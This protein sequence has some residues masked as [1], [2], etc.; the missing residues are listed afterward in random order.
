MVDSV[1]NYGI[2]GVSSTVELGKQGA[3]IDASNSSVITIK[4]KDDDLINAAIAEGTDVSHAVTK[5]QLDAAGL[6]KVSVTSATVSYNNTTVL[7]GI[8]SA[9]ATVLSTTVEPLTTWTDADANTNITVGDNTDPDRLFT[10]FDPSVQT[11]DETNHMYTSSE[12]IFI[13]VSQG[14]ASAGTA[15]VSVVHSGLINTSAEAVTVDYLIVGGGGGGG[16][17]YD[18]A[19]GGGGGGGMVL[20]ANTNL[21]VGITYNI[22]VGTGGSGG[23]D[24]RASSPGT[25]GSDSS[26]AGVTALGGGRGYGSR[27]NTLQVGAAQVGSTTAP[28]GGGGGA[29]GQ[30]G[31]GGGGATGAAVG[32]F[33]GAGLASSI[34][35]TSITYST[36]GQGG[37]A[38]APTTNGSNGAANSGNGGGG[39]KS[40]SSDSAAGGAGGSG[41]VIISYPDSY[42]AATT[43]GTVTATTSGG[44]R[45][46]TFTGNGTIRV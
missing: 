26:F 41:V 22:V 37:G 24:V 45:I 31:K 43:T 29:G 38:G 18:N 3:V 1:K 23:S 5:N 34:T 44:Y 7:L 33:A 11:S 28:T 15:K 10:G 36:G 39:G 6:N 25:D 40:A 17:A 20:T 42:S 30:A 9:N 16:N 32:V 8:L 12:G 35:G 13:T 27:D 2:T 21:T 46:Y 4:D 14:A 19:G